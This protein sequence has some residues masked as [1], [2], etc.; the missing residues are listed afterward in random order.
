MTGFTTAVPGFNDVTLGTN[1]GYLATPGWDYTTGLGS[2]NISAI[3][4]LLG[5]VAA[6]CDAGSDA[7]TNHPPIAMLGASPSNGAAPLAVSFSAAGSGDPDAGDSIASY[8]FNFGDSSSPVTQAGSTASHTYTVAGTYTASVTATDTHG[9]TSIAATAT[10]TASASP[11]ATATPAATPAPTATPTPT[12]T[13]TPTA[14]AATSS[15]PAAF[16]ATTTSTPGATPSPTPTPAAKTSAAATDSSSGGGAIG[17]LSLIPLMGAAL[18]RRR[19]RG[20]SV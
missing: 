2:F 17:W 6:T 15:P 20:L 12:P 14:A 19:N 9:A 10:I 16:S 18:R 13:S 8:T 7:T 1:G 11:T 3:N 4:P 5:P